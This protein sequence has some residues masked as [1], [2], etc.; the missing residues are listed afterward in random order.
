MTGV[1]ISMQQCSSCCRDKRDNAVVGAL[2][3]HRTYERTGESIGIVSAA[4]TT[5]TMFIHINN[6]CTK[7]L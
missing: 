1:K 4:R 2:L 6:D 5:V 7:L 3:I